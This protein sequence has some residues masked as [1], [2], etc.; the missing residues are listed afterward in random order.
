MTKSALRS[1]ALALSKDCTPQG[2]LEME[3]TLGVP[4]EITADQLFGVYY[5]CKCGKEFTTYAR[6][7][8]HWMEE[9]GAPNPTGDAKGD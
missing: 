2:A 1:G 6:F 9:C 5:V 4:P 7:S 8:T 3:D